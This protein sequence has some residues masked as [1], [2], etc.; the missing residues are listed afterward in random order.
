M[1]SSLQPLLPLIIWKI[2]E[3]IFGVADES[4]SRNSIRIEAPK[5]NLLGILVAAEVPLIDHG[6]SACRFPKVM[7]A[8]THT[9]KRRVGEQGRGLLP[10]GNP[11]GTDEQGRQALTKLKGQQKIPQTF[12]IRTIDLKRFCIGLQGADA[13]YLRFGSCTEHLVTFHDDAARS[14]KPAA[15]PKITMPDEERAKCRQ[16]ILNIYRN[17]LTG[18]DK[19]RVQGTDAAVQLERV[20]DLHV[21]TESEIRENLWQR[22]KAGKCL[23][24]FQMYQEAADTFLKG[25]QQILWLDSRG[26]LGCIEWTGLKGVWSSLAQHYYDFLILAAESCTQDVSRC[27]ESLGWLGRA[28]SDTGESGSEAGPRTAT[29]RSNAAS[30]VNEGMTARDDAPLSGVS[31]DSL[32]HQSRGISLSGFEDSYSNKNPR[33][34]DI[35]PN[36]CRSYLQRAEK[37]LKRVHGFGRFGDVEVQPDSGQRKRIDELHEKISNLYEALKAASGL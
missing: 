1:P 29:E 11:W 26:I 37:A 16:L 9:I 15:A 30:S 25:A 27:L 20:G 17:T 33:L 5:I 8:A 35:E 10:T 6:E 32:V 34:N 21:L 14:E 36:T 18:F 12:V 3:V 31:L 19:F 28:N 4:W 23:V 24:G 2:F 13:G 22:L 7:L